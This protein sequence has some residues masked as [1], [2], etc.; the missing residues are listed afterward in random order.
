MSTDFER[1]I[2]NELMTVEKC[3]D[4]SHTIQL[5]AARKQALGSKQPAW[6]SGLRLI[7]WPAAGMALASALAFMLVLNPVIPLPAVPAA[8][9]QLVDE[10]NFDNFELIDDLDFYYWLADTEMNLRG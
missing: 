4:P 6:F 10:Q 3:F 8:N 2:R 7:A 1:K 5:D 9:T